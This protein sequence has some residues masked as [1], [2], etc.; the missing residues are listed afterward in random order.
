MR[1]QDMKRLEKDKHLNHVR[2][3]MKFTDAY[4]YRPPFV[5]IVYP[6]FKRST[7][8]IIDGAFCMELL[9]NQARFT[10]R[11]VTLTSRE[12]DAVFVFTHLLGYQ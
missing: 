5:R 9:T 6:R 7:G 1:A 3:M 2:L 11:S 10:L 4:P 8:Y 12:T